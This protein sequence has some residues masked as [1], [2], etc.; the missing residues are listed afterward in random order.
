MKLF[1]RFKKSLSEFLYPDWSVPVE[2]LQEESE[3]IPKLIPFVSKDEH[4]AEIVVD[5]DFHPSILSRSCL[6][7][8]TGRWR[9]VQRDEKEPEVQFECFIDPDIRTHTGEVFMPRVLFVPE[10]RL[11]ITVSRTSPIY[12]C[13]S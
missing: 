9:V 10:H 13:G 12:E 5:V 1:N 8:L 6:I 11:S 3:T 7:G 2:P 4:G